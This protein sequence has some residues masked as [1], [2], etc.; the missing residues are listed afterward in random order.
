[1]DVW[2][3][4]PAGGTAL[5]WRVYRELRN[6]PFEL[7]SGSSSIRGCGCSRTPSELIVSKPAPARPLHPSSYTKNK[8][9]PTIYEWSVSH[10][11]NVFEAKSED[12]CIRALDETFSQNIDFTTN[13]KQ[14][15]RADLQ[16]FVLTMVN[17]SGFRLKVQ[18]QNALEVP[19]DDSNRVSR[20]VAPTR[21]Y[22]IS[23]PCRTVSSVDTTSSATSA[24]SLRRAYLSRPVLSAINL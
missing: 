16:R 9:L 5:T 2:S 18:W 24:N 3:D 11:Q 4:S 1:M 6:F 7:P 8:M 10:I 22:L 12:E 17:A 13:G 19:R 15:G 20:F 14:L 23:F 21:S